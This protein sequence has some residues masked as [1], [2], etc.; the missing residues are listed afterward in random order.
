MAA[1]Q[2]P[3]EKPEQAEEWLKRHDEWRRMETLISQAHDDVEKLTD[4]IKHTRKIF[5]ELAGGIAHEMN[6]LL[7]VIGGH[8]DILHLSLRRDDP[9]AESVRLII[10]AAAR[11]AVL[12]RR[13]TAFKQSV[14]SQT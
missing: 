1:V 6:N 5:S 13:L 11:A 8:A 10:D 12:T 3:S 4:Q 9:N 7:T 14:L 2:F